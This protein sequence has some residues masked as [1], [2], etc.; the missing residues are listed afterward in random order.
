L[1]DISIAIARQHARFTNAQTYN[2]TMTNEY[3]RST[4]TLSPETKTF[5]DEAAR[6]LNISA[7]SYMRVLRVSRTIADLADSNDITIAH[8]SEALRYRPTPT[9]S[10]E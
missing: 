3:I 6:Q 1:P 2:S 7:R 10:P 4:C 8:I 5:L 9:K